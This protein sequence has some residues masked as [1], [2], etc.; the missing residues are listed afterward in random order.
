MKM[1][2]RNIRILVK[3][4]YRYHYLIRHRQIFHFR[5]HSRMNNENNMC[6]GP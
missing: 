1:K 3:R 6:D 4:N 5:F 2:T